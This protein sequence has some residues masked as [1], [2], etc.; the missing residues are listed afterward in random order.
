[1]RQV[2]KNWKDL[3]RVCD[4]EST[5]WGQKMIQG[6][7]V[8]VYRDPVDESLYGTYDCDWPEPTRL[9]VSDELINDPNWVLV[10][11]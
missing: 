8:I 1:M 7:D 10:E 11:F 4:D 3:N 5:I 6:E 2:F 9:L